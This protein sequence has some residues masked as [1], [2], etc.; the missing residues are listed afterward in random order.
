MIYEHLS[1]IKPKAHHERKQTIMNWKLWTWPAQM[2]RLQ[3]KA[4]DFEAAHRALLLEKTQH[5]GREFT[6]RRNLSL[7]RR[8]LSRYR[9]QEGMDDA[10]IAAAFESLLENKGFEAILAL[11]TEAEMAAMDRM[12]EDDRPALDMKKDAGAVDALTNFHARLIDLEDQA[13]RTAQRKNHQ[14]A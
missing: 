14:A 4:A 13:R 12:T 9:K 3:E 1:D 10:E 5:N 11:L 8:A 7:A 6:V 2:R